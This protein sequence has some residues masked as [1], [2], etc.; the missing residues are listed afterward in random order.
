MRAILSDIRALAGVTGVAVLGKSDG[1]V[2]HQFPAAFTDRHTERLLELVT[3]TYQRLRG[4]SR[5]TLRFERVIVH[6]FNQ[7][8]Y[9]LLVTIL[10]EASDQHFESVVRSK[11]ARIGHVLAKTDPVPGGLRVKKTGPSATIAD[12]ITTLIDIFNTMTQD[13]SGINPMSKL[14]ADWRRARDNA[15][16]QFEVLAAVAVDTNG[17]LA[18]RKGRSPEPNAATIE[19]FAHLVETFLQSLGI[20][21]TAAE[22]S[23][24]SQVERYRD[25][26]EPYGLFLFLGKSHRPVRR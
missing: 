14:A 19:A 1:R 13:L 15:T 18:I 6:L 10:P 26:L 22:E 16:Q 7:P 20:H 4:F 9:L 12:P 24:Y 25:I 8:E 11:F 23:L 17:R 21:R 3:Q 2:E 5:L